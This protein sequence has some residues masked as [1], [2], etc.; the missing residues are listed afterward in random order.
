[1]ANNCRSTFATQRVFSRS[2]RI[3]FT[4]WLRFCIATILPGPVFSSIMEPNLINAKTKRG[5]RVKCSLFFARYDASTII[6]VTRSRNYFTRSIIIIII[7]RSSCDKIVNNLL[8]LRR[9]R[10]IIIFSTRRIACVLPTSMLLHIF[11]NIGRGVSRRVA[12]YTANIY[13]YIS[14]RRPNND[15]YAR[16][17][18]RTHTHTHVPVTTGTRLTGELIVPRP[19]PVMGWWLVGWLMVVV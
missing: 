10:I 4:R 16:P 8:Y 19:V 9:T 3:T 2:L 15:T 1:M 17:C 7:M 18:A 11:T 13:S 5:R 14:C 6:I 12:L